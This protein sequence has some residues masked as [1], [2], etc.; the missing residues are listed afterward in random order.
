[1]V[2][3][4]KLTPFCDAPKP[5]VVIA[6]LGWAAALL[7]AKRTAAVPLSGGGP[8]PAHSLAGSQA[9]LS[10]VPDGAGACQGF[11]VWAGG[12]TSASHGLGEALAE[13][14][15]E[16]G[17]GHRPLA[18]RHPPLLLGA[19]QDQEQQLHRRLVGRK[20][21]PGPHRPAKL[22]VERLDR[23]RRVQQPPD[24][25]GE[26]VERHHL[27]PGA[28]PA[29]AD[30]RVLA[31]P[32][33]LLEGGER[34]LAGSGVDRAVDV[35]QRRSHGRAVLIGDKGQALAQQ[36]DDAGLDRGLRENGRDCLWK[37]LQAVDDRDQ[38]I[39]H[40]PV[41]EL[42][43]DLQPELGALVLLKPQAQD[44]LR[45]VCPDAQG[46]VDRLVPDQAFIA[47]LD[48]E[49]VEEDQRVDRL[50]RPG[51]PGRDLLE[52]RVR[53]RADQV[54][55]D[56]DAV[57]LA[58]VADDLPRA[59]APGVHRDDLVV[60][61]WEA[62]LVLGDQLRVEAR[63][64]VPGDL[65]LD[66]A[67][68]GEDALAAVAVAAVAGLLTAEMMIH[69]RVQRPLG[70]GLLQAV[71][72]AVR[73]ERRL[74]IGPGQKLVEDGVGD[75][76]LFA[77]RHVGAPSLPSCPLTHEIPDRAGSGVPP[78]PPCA[79]GW[80]TGAPPPCCAGSMPPWSGWC[81]RDPRPLRGTWWSIA[82]R[83]GP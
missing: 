63:L 64:P 52:H 11:R 40:T 7:L 16:L 9:G 33:T 78:V 79:V 47:D 28:A 68:V 8:E 58:Q 74:R 15:G 45:P 61:A 69:L 5:A 12:W 62:A 38:D 23:V 82:A 72:E 20:V 31:A 35:P 54:R 70:Q 56:L 71:E 4:K 1:M 13:E 59:H 48:P 77:S 53:H 3:I 36:M 26:G 34:R 60:E 67:G 42:V 83:S 6:V 75:L 14:D 51:L 66:L 29:L 50:Q 37:A 30:G 27:S 41:F 22:G 18:R 49:R 10:A 17:L 24:V 44:L 81:A 57:E 32:G 21:A 46:D 76:E 43:H 73:I 65:E 39:L 55:R 2:A 19:V 80:T 25:A